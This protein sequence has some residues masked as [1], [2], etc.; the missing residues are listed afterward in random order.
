MI[1]D[2]GKPILL[3]DF[4]GTLCHDRFWRS[5]D[6]KHFDQIQELIF[7]QNFEYIDEWMRGKKTAEEV[8]LFVADK[9]NIPYEH[10]WSL[11]VEDCKTL[12]IDKK[13]LELIDGLR[14]KYIVV[15]MT[16][17]MDTLMRFTV[18]ALNLD[19]HFDLIVSSADRGILKHDENG[20]LFTDIIQELNGNIKDTILIDNSRKVCDLF[21]ALGGKPLYVDKEKNLTYWLKTLS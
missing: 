21:E 18:P 1:R 16:N 11:F 3:I 5:L 12:Y 19:V 9:L 8:N 4:D 2:M 10:L 17:N 13:D 6:V 7:N 15:L 20:K 14:E